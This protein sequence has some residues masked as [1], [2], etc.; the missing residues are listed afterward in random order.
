MDG[1]LLATVIAQAQG[2]WMTTEL[3]PF[4]TYMVAPSTVHGLHMLILKKDNPS[5]LPEHDASIEIP[6]VIK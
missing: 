5:G 6:V 3:V 4:S 2:E 1:E